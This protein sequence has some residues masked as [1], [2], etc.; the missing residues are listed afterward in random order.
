[1]NGRGKDVTYTL[2]LPDGT[3]RDLLK[4]YMW[5]DDW[6]PSYHLKTPIAAPKGSRLEVV[7]HFDNSAANE[8]NPDPKQRVRHGDETMDAFFEYTLDGQRP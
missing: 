8:N 3:R 5:E 7:A 1:M 2:V 6:E 4:L